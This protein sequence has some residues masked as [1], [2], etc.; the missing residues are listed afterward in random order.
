MRKIEQLY[1][2][3][4]SVS[5]SPYRTVLRG[6]ALCT[7]VQEVPQGAR[8]CARSIQN[9]KPPLEA[10]SDPWI[11][12]RRGFVP[13]F[14]VPAK[15]FPVLYV[16]I[17]AHAP[18]IHKGPAHKAAPSPHCPPWWPPLRGPSSLRLPFSPPARTRPACCLML[19]LAGCLPAFPF[20]LRKGFLRYFLYHCA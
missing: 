3:E 11:F 4:L 14:P 13:L 9:K 10:P 12:C 1:S 8:F 18:H 19:W 16:C 17:C 6:P 7:V 5:P 15:R 20:C 2:L